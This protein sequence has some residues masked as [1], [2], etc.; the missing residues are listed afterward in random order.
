MITPLSQAQ[1]NK[2]GQLQ[3]IM[4]N[5]MT[6]TVSYMGTSFTFS[7]GSDAW[8]FFMDYVLA[9]PGGTNFPSAFAIPDVNGNSVAM[10]WDQALTLVQTIM[11]SGLAVWQHYQTKVASVMSA[12]T[13]TDVLAITW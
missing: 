13:I 6:F 2:I 5:N 7:Y 9:F 1:N 8:N 4:L 12:I 11:N 3:Q 10:T